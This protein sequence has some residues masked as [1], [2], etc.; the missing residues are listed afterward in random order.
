VEEVLATTDA[1]P[2]PRSVNSEAGGI[3]PWQRIIVDR[4]ESLLAGLV[5]TPG[6]Q[7]KERLLGFAIQQKGWSLKTTTPILELP[8]DW[9]DAC[10]DVA[11]DPSLEQWRDSYRAWGQINGLTTSEI[12]ACTLERKEHRL[13]TGVGRSLLERLRAL[14][15]EIFKGECWLLAGEGRF[16]AAAVLECIETASR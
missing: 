1:G 11:D 13:R 2:D 4:S 16:R 15:P 8:Q 6:D 7:G 5:L 12:D 14:H 10:P 9:R 3:S